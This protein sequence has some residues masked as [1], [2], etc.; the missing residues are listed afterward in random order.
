MDQVTAVAAV[1]SFTT[2]IAALRKLSGK[3]V[4]Y[5][6][7]VAYATDDVKMLAD[8]VFN[9]ARL[10]A[11]LENTLNGLPQQ[12]LASFKGDAL[13]D[14]YIASATVLVDRLKILLKGLKPLRCAGDT[15]ILQRISAPLK[16]VGLKEKSCVLRSYL[17][18]SMAG[19]Q[20]FVSITILASLKTQLERMRTSVDAR[21]EDVK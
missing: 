13:D 8:E 2:V 18:S 20:L 1:S 17:H 7:D 5:S 16:W 10:L 9:F 12:V 4:R 6:K 14:H 15:S 11:N 3:L 21:D 19:V